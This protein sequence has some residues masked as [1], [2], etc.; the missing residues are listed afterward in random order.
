M[1]P[2]VPRSTVRRDTE[3]AVDRAKIFQ[4]KIFRAGGFPAAPAHG[5]ERAPFQRALAPT[6]KWPGIALSFAAWG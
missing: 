2:D 3:R 4:A 5:R 6:P 1:A